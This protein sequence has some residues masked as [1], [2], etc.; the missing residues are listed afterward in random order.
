[1]D[2]SA[3][4]DRLSPLI[5]SAAAVVGELDLSRLLRRLISEAMAATG[6]RYAALGVLGEHGVLSDFLYEGVDAEVAEKI[7]HLPTGRGVLGTMIRARKTLMLDDISEHPDS[8]GFPPNH[9]PMTTFLGVP[10]TAGDSTYGNLYLTE[11]DGGFTEDDRIVVEALSH[12]AGAAIQTAR[13]QERLK[14]VAVVEDRQR[15]ARDLHDS[16]IQDL[17]AVGLGLQELTRRIDDPETAQMVD[18]AVDRLDTSVNSLRRYIFEL[19]DPSHPNLT[20]DERLQDLVSRMGSAYPSTVR[21]SIDWIGPTTSDD[22]IIMLVQEGLSNSLRHGGAETVEISIDDEDHNVVIKVED[23]GIG[24]DQAAIHDGMGLPNMRSRVERLG[25]VMTV[26]SQIGEG[27][28]VQI[29]LPVKQPD[30]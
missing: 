10:V 19:K 28:T 2:R 30:G 8:Y 13:L 29:W 22:E 16:V 12:V 23:D 20:L 5:E 18:E 24:F 6:A 11:K 21:L 27:T 17:F 3:T 14:L 9:P 15:I 25:G 7:G 26:D 4:L 1:M